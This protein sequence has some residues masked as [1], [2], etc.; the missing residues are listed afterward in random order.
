LLLAVEV[1]SPED[2]ATETQKKVEEYLTGGVPLIWI[3][4]WNR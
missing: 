4:E 1:L 2:T 3:V